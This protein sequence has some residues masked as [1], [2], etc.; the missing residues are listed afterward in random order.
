[1]ASELF[2]VG[3]EAAIQLEHDGRGEIAIRLLEELLKAGGSGLPEIEVARLRAALAGMLWKRGEVA[4]AR[5]LAADALKLA[6]R[7]AH[8]EAQSEALFELGEVTYIEAAYMGRGSLDDA[9]EAHRRALE[10]RCRIGDRRGESL[11]LSRIGVIHERMDEQDEAQAC[12][13]RALGIAEELDFPEGMSRPYVHIGVAKQL[14]GDLVGALVD[15]RRSVAAVRRAHDVRA[16]AFDLCNVAW[17]AHQLDGDLEA[18]LP[19][20]AEAR[21]YAEGMS[22]KLGELRVRQ[23][24]GDVYAAAGRSEDAR[25]EYEAA[26]GIGEAAELDRFVSFVRERLAELDKTAEQAED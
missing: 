3:R 5:A 24:T 14:A 23:V 17:T 26:I 15:Y 16:L 18:V 11:S 6:E 13:E 9:L 8:D 20:L 2:G 21:E 7:A 4:K 12:Y 22:F 1:V 10:I 19:L 25:R